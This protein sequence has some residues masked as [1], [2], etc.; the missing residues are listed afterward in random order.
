MPGACVH[1]ARWWPPGPSVRSRLWET[2]R[3]RPDQHTAHISRSARAQQPRWRDHREAV[4]RGT[5]GFA[6][7]F[8]AIEG[9]DSGEDMGAVGVLR[10]TGLQDPQIAAL[11]EQRVKQDVFHATGN[12]PIAEGT[13]HTEMKARIG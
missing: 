5:H 3:C 7:P 1:P 6:D 9:S 12:Q 2:A 13:E 8:E 10:T 11:L 4:E